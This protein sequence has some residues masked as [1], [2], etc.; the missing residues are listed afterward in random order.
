MDIYMAFDCETGG[1]SSAEHSLLTGHFAFMTREGNKFTVIDDLDLALKDPTGKYRTTYEAMNVNKIDLKEHDKIAIE[2]IE[3]SK[4][5]FEKIEKHSNR[6]QNKIILV[7]QNI[8]F[9]EGFVFSYLIPKTVWAKYFLTDPKQKLDTKSILKKAKDSGKIP[10]DQS[11]SLGPAAKFLGI[12]VTDSE[13]HGAKYDTLT[14]I[15]VLEKA[16]EKYGK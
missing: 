5:L 6:G 15:K 12:E 7:G 9:D 13:L 16:L 3:G 8:P 2:C 11:I 1:L 10:K 14:C 4:L